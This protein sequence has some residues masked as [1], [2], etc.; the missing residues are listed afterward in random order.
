MEY[1]D[2]VEVPSRLQCGDDGRKE[3]E[4]VHVVVESLKI[5]LFF[6]FFSSTKTNLRWN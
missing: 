2:Y 3:G 1:Y 4:L 5:L 6:L